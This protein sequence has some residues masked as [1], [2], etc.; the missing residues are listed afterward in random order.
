VGNALA[1]GLECVT[2]AHG[3]RRDGL[4]HLQ[5]ADSPEAAQLLIFGDHRSFA[6]MAMTLPGIPT[7]AHTNRGRRTAALTTARTVR[8]TQ[9]NRIRGEAVPDAWVSTTTRATQGTGRE[10]GAPY[11]RCPNAC[12]HASPGYSSQR[13]AYPIFDAKIPQRQNDFKQREV[14]LGKDRIGPAKQPREACKHDRVYEVASAWSCNSERGQWTMDAVWLAI[15]DSKAY[16]NA[17]R[18]DST[19]KRLSV[20]SRSR[21]APR[22]TIL[23][24]FGD[25]VTSLNAD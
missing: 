7:A 19:T 11:T 5:R 9:E 22:G 2:A 12:I 13:L 3:S 24:L 18:T 8:I 4:G 14:Q 15:R 23:E 16:R 21:L 20:W 1:I 25:F 17:P 10:R 6:T